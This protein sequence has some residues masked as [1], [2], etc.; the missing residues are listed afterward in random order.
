MLFRVLCK[1]PLI[2][3]G[4]NSSLLRKLMRI[5]KIA[6]ILLFAACMNVYADGF[7]Q[8]LT[9]SEKNASLEKVLR[10]IHVQSGYLFFYEL[11]LLKKAHPVN[12]Q[13]KDAA[14]DEVLNICF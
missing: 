4:Y 12:I 10:K 8:K 11:D 7:A 13:V 14:L 9:L 2:T 1:P 5:M 3:T 6:F